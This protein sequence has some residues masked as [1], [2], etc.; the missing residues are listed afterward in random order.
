MQYDPKFERLEQRIRKIGE[1]AALVAAIVAAAAVYH[2]LPNQLFGWDGF[3]AVVAVTAF[4]LVDAFL[5]T[6][7]RK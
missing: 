2:F 6:Y 7:F 1:I 5:T 4:V 3:D